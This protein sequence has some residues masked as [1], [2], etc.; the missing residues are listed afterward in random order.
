MVNLDEIALGV[1]LPDLGFFAVLFAGMIDVG[2][3]IGFDIGLALLSFE[4]RDL[5]S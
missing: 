2:L 5:I 3:E 1:L 4:A